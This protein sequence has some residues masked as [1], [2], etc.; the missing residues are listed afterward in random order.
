MLIY[1]SFTN[2]PG[3]IWISQEIQQNWK[4]YKF[5]K[6]RIIKFCCRWMNSIMIKWKSCT[7]S[8]A[9]S[10]VWIRYFFEKTKCVVLHWLGAHSQKRNAPKPRFSNFT[11]RGD[12]LE[13]QKSRFYVGQI[14]F[15]ARQC[16][17]VVGSAQDG[18]RAAGAEAISGQD[19]GSRPMRGRV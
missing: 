8:A 7:E 6:K 10:T 12:G 14:H 11:L 18:E 2:H 3:R 15:E 9:G 17:E 19:P 5:C 16:A 4:M 1:W 13:N